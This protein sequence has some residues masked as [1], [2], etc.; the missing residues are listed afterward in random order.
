VD[1]AVI[2]DAAEH[3]LGFS[4]FAALSPPA[5]DTGL[6]QLRRSAEARGLAFQPFPALV[7]D[8]PSLRGRGDLEAGT[9][10]VSIVHLFRIASVVAIVEAIGPTAQED[11]ISAEAQHGAEQQRD[12]LVAALGH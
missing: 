9:P 1:Y 11:S 3:T 2:G 6:E 7:G 5:A 8:S 4:L 10:M 12:K